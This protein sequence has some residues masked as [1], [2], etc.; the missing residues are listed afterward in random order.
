MLTKGSVAWWQD[1]LERYEAVRGKVTQRAFCEREGV[2][3][4]AFVYRMFGEWPH[5]K[6]GQ[7][8]ASA[9]APATPR[10]V[11]VAVSQPVARES[12]WVEAEVPC[13]V[14]LRFGAGTDEAYVTALL[15][16]LAMG[17]NPVSAG[18]VR[19]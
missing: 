7:G 19:C 12:V 1:L 4:G 9:V 14:V 2:A 10:M 3:L 11:P 18:V 13:G 16:R 17:R 8:V 15:L 6:R 5:R